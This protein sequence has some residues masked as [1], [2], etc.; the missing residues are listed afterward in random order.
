MKDRRKAE[1][2]LIGIVLNNA[3]RSFVFEGVK[4]DDFG[5]ETARCV[6][7][8]LLRY[9]KEN[10]STDFTAVINLMDVE[11]QRLVLEADGDYYPSIDVEGQVKE[12]NDDLTLERMKTGAA[13]LLQAE[14]LDE[15][16]E[17]A[18][19]IQQLARGVARSKPLSFSEASDLFA[20]DMSETVEYIPTGY[21]KLD[22]YALIDRGDFIVLAG[23]QSSGKTALSI[24]LMLNMAKH[25][26]RCVYFSLE[27]AAMGIFYKA[28]S[29]FTGL[30][31]SKILRRDLTDSEKETYNM[32]W[33][34]LKAM[35]VTIVEAAGWPVDRIRA[36]AIRLDADIV[37]IDYIGLIKGNGRSRYEETTAVS[38]DLHTMAQS[39]GITIVCLSQQGRGSDDS[40]H[41]LKDSGQLESDADM[42]LI[43]TRKD[44]DRTKIKWETDLTIAKN[45]KGR[46]GAIPMY[47]DGTCQQFTQIYT[48]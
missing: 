20:A 17:I 37:F 8:K 21:H 45:K 7:R 19:R 27:T 10:G 44:P 11:E 46:V 48:S 43:L 23:E 33:D 5:D 13:Q 26:Y 1:I 34:T 29:M 16:S 35:P 47:F 6:Y 40:M 18:S 36:E 22:E 39:T 38:I 12:F 25:D 30:P 28:V 14:D 42:V 32:A 15:G 41:S 9:W 2:A 24:G 4:E 31:Y 3:K